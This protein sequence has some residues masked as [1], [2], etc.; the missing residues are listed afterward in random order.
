MELKEPVKELTMILGEINANLTELKTDIQ[1]STQQ[2][3][4]DQRHEASVIKQQ[5]VGDKS[6]SQLADG[7]VGF[8]QLFTGYSPV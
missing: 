4:D 8:A 6:V 7:E 2:T 5:S 1:M 3:S